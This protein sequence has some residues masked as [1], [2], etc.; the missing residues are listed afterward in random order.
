MDEH[1]E[2]GG[3]ALGQ[4]EVVGV[5]RA[6]PVGQAQAAY[7]LFLPEGTPAGLAVFVHGGY[8]KAFDRSVWSH[9]ARSRKAA[10]SA[11]MSAMRASG[12]S[13]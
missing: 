4:E 3:C 13:V 7:D 8:W 10:I 1:R 9:L 5:A 11:V 2:A 6:R 12:Q